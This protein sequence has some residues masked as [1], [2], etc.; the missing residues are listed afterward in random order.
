M[1]VVNLSQHMSG[2]VRDM[3]YL[4]PDIAATVN[5][6]ASIIQHLPWSVRTVPNT[7]TDLLDMQ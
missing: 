1:G 7:N 3:V 5:D 4:V 6:S 2:A